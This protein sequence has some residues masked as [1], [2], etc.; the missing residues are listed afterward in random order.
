MPKEEWEL[1]VRDD[2]GEV[3][4]AHHDSNVY[5]ALRQRPSRALEAALVRVGMEPYTA[6]SSLCGCKVIYYGK[7]GRTRQRSNEPLVPVEM[8]K[9]IFGGL[10]GSVLSTDYPSLFRGKYK[11]FPDAS[12]TFR[13]RGST[14]R[15]RAI[16]TG[17]QL[18]I[19]F[20]GEPL[21][22]VAE[23]LDA[24]GFRSNDDVEAGFQST[25]SISDTP[26][27]RIACETIQ[28]RMFKAL[29]GADDGLGFDGKSR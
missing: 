21:R 12:P 2:V 3:V 27:A 26:Q 19:S 11:E 7:G 22:S 6:R 9:A 16:A 10:P 1:A 23:I 15:C 28:S 18:H 29:P 25:W 24:F 5:L 14:M 20:L 8:R 13:I 17:K 4:F